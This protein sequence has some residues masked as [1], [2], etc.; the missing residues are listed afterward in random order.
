VAG[1]FFTHGGETAVGSTAPLDQGSTGEVAIL[2]EIELQGELVEGRPRASKSRPLS[3][4]IVQELTS[5]EVAD[6]LIDDVPFFAT[7]PATG[8]A[9]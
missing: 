5:A 1:P 8:S 4:A 2:A 3:Q 6:L 9:C 7:T